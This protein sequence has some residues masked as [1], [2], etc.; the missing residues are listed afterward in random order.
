M[1]LVVLASAFD[2]TPV[3]VGFPIERGWVADA[4]ASG[5]AVR[6]WLVETGIVP[7]FVPGQ[8]ARA[9]AGGAGLVRRNCLRRPCS[10]SRLGGHA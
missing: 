1:L 9:G 7:G 6:G 3:L 2:G 8:P 5:L 10:G 4:R